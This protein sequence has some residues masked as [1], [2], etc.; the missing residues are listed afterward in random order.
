MTLDSEQNYVWASG[1]TEV[2]S[3]VVGVMGAWRD[4]IGLVG[5]GEAFPFMEFTRLA[6]AYEEGNQVAV[7]WGI[8]VDGN[9]FPSYRDLLI[10]LREDRKIGQA[11][12]FF[13]HGTLRLS[14]DWEDPDAPEIWIRSVGDASFALWTLGNPE[15][16]QE[17]ADLASLTRAVGSL[18]GDR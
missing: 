18:L 6:L 11:F 9:S 17:F 16:R 15:Q 7:Q 2:L 10:A 8:L 1:S 4:G 12:P 13:S 5:L 14:N 3:D